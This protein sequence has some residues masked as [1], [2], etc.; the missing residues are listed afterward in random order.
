MRSNR[1]SFE[2]PYST[3]FVLYST[4]SDTTARAMRRA[5]SGSFTT[6]IAPSLAVFSSSPLSVAKR[7]IH[8]SPVPVDQQGHHLPS[9]QPPQQS[10]VGIPARHPL[11]VDPEEDVPLANPAR[12]GHAR[13]VHF[14]DLHSA[15]DAKGVRHPFRKGLDGES[16]CIHRGFPGNGPGARRLQFGQRHGERHPLPHAQDL[17]DGKGARGDARH[18]LLEFLYT[19]HSHPSEGDHDVPPEETRRR[20]PTSGKDT[21]DQHPFLALDAERFRPFGGQELKADAEPAA[22]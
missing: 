9:G 6:P 18:R 17:Q 14:P 2:I 13:R 15:G 8:L 7:Q 11:P 16:P 5:T 22:P 12:T 10:P 1:L 4:M 21:I 3:F 20:R 19:G